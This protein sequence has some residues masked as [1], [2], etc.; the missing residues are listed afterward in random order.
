MYILEKL[1]CCSY[2]KVKY[3]NK[4]CLYPNVHFSASEFEI[5]DTE[6]VIKWCIQVSSY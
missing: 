4:M 6:L 2:L 3:S 5:H 1:F